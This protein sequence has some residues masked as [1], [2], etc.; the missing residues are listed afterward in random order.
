MAW[1]QMVCKYRWGKKR[2]KSFWG[3]LI[4]PLWIRRSWTR[5]AGRMGCKCRR[6]AN[7]LLGAAVREISDMSAINPGG[8]VVLEQVSFLPAWVLYVA[9][10]KC[11]RCFRAMQ[12]SAGSGRV[13]RSRRWI[14]KHLVLRRPSPSETKQGNH[15]RRAT[16]AKCEL[17]VTW[18]KHHIESFFKKPTLTVKT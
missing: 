10:A 3:L 5:T 12:K 15:G 9:F 1:L 14:T 4:F 17:Q 13:L 6:K 2:C 16:P 18:Q 8:V 7:A 11:C